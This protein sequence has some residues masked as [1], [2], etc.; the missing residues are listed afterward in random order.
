MY[1]I[2]I[3]VGTVLKITGNICQENTTDSG[4]ERYRDSRKTEAEKAGGKQK[5]LLNKIETSAEGL[6]IFLAFQFMKVKNDGFRISSD[7]IID[8]A[9]DKK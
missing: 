4:S 5:F 8:I 2:R 7:V 3:H 9:V 6:E 1:K